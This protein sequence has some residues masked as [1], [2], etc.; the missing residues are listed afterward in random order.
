MKSRKAEIVRRVHALPT[1]AFDEDRSLTSFSGLVLFQ[2]LFQSLGLL[3]R[4][5]RC[6]SHL[7]GSRVYGLARI[8]LQLIVHVLVGFRRLR[9]RDYYADDP[10]VCRVLGVSKLAD[11]ATI[12]RTLAAGDE[13]S[14]EN[15]RGVVREGVLERVRAEQLPR[16]TLDFDGSVLSTARHAEGSAVGYN[17][18]RKGA[19]SYYPL[20]CVISQLGMFF[21]ML[22]RAGN[23]HD[24]NGA[25]AF[26]RE[27]VE[28][29]RAE[30]GRVVLEA[31]LDTAFFDE[32]VLEMLEELKVEY[33]AAV[34]F[35]RFVKLRY[36][37]DSRTH[38]LPIDDEW[39]YF[40]ISWRPKTWSKRRRIIL[41]RRRRKTRLKGPLQ[42][43]IFEPVSHEYEYK[44]IVTNKKVTAATVIQFLNGRGV[45]EATYGEAKQ[46]A[47]LGYI[48]CRRLV[49]NQLFTLSS[50]LAHNLSREL[51]LRANPQ[52][53]RCTR[54]RACQFAVSTLGTIRDRL[55]RRAGRLSRPQGRLTLTVA[56]SEP[57]RDEFE[58]F[59]EHLRAA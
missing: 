21:D 31:R 42:L 6:F 30:L 9:D 32:R 56:A 15:L 59:L 23:V 25:V 40:E 35:A 2:A 41:V 43:D 44:A 13:R 57:A 8:L 3:A 28:R 39:S 17:P 14:V 45:Q 37:V 10:L 16:L 12:S 48:P 54:T 55:L 20:F 19:R 47:A 4:L 51:Q 33:A 49:A 50:L 1:L 11:T 34:P 53:R 46:Y 36:L 29:V 18:K 5:R 22:H 7:G 24:S 58:G 26:I 38:W 52:R 27:C